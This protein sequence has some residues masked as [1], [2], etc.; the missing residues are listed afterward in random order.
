MTWSGE[1]LPTRRRAEMSSFTKFTSGAA[2]L[3]G[4]MMGCSSSSSPSG[5]NTPDGGGGNDSGGGG[6]DATVGNDSGG[7]GH[8]GGGGSDA[9]P[10]CMLAANGQAVYGNGNPPCDAC[11]QG[12][13]CCAQ[14]N[15]CLASAGCTKIFQCVHGSN[16][17][18]GGQVPGC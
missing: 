17:V 2:L 16:T 3:L 12:T 4:G 10:S 14:V 15:T 8:D 9:G 11:L 18:D 6:N 7:G 13:P 1:S 5:T